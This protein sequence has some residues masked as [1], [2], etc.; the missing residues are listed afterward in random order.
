MRIGKE[1]SERK[2]GKENREGKVGKKNREGKVGKENQKVKVG[3]E[4]REGKSRRKVGKQNRKSRERKV[5]KKCR[6]RKV[7]NESRKGREPHNKRRMEWK[8]VRPERKLDERRK[9]GGTMQER[10]IIGSWER[11]G[12]MKGQKMGKVG[13]QVGG[14]EVMQVNR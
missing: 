3:N 7:R 8:V 14:W 11:A 12:I 13:R 5:G 6:E 2:V 1:K 10:T 4:S 9:N